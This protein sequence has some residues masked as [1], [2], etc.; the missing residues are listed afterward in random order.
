MRAAEAG[1]RAR[2]HRAEELGMVNQA[3]GMLFV[4]NRD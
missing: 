2:M 4:V 3:G 1:F